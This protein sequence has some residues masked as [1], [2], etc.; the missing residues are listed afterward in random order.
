MNM[1]IL[2]KMKVATSNRYISPCA[3]LINAEI[4]KVFGEPACCKNSME[5]VLSGRKGG[6]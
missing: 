6:P 2:L 5:Q 4:F 1:K 3:S